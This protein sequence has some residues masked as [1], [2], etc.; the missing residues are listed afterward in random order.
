MPNEKKQ[1]NKALQL[2]GAGTQMGVTIWAFSKL[3]Q[4]L[5]TLN[6]F[7]ASFSYEAFTLFGVFIALYSLI[8]QLNRLNE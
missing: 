3:G 4:Y 5:T 1:P 6:W 8:K 2:A 7:G